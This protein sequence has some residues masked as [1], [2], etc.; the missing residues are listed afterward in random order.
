MPPPPDSLAATAIQ[1]T[2]ADGPLLRRFNPAERWVHRGFAVLM[3]VDMLTALALYS[4]TLSNTIGQRGL[5]RAIHVYVGLALPLP[6]LLGTL[7]SAY[8]SDARRLNRFTADDWRWLNPRE[9]RR[10]PVSTGKFNAG[11]KLNTA[12]TAGATAVLLGTGLVMYLRQATP[13]DWRIG[14]TFVHGW[15]AFSLTALVLGHI[16]LATLDAGARGGLRTG[17]V[18]R[19]WAARHHGEWLREC[20]GGVPAGIPGPDERP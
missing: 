16:V 14:A 2:E 9:R 18:T 17:F 8:R 5:V 1:G 19:T 13:L 3:T 15:T 6:L 10:A 4:S 7:S 11:Q 12:L 20:G